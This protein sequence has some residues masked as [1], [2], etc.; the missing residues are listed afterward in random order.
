MFYFGYSK[1]NSFFVC[2]M[3]CNVTYT[4]WQISSN[5]SCKICLFF[6]STSFIQFKSNILKW[7]IRIKNCKIKYKEIHLFL[8]YQKKK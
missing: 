4:F 5:V 8:D 3:G 2:F 1:V 6:K 7:E